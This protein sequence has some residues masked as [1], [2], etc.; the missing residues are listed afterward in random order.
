MILLN[1]EEWEQAV[2]S[3]ARDKPGLR[4]FL[5]AIRERSQLVSG[6]RLGHPSA[7]VSAR[8]QTVDGVKAEK[9]P[10]HLKKNRGLI[11]TSMPIVGLFFNAAIA[12]GEGDTCA[13]CMYFA[14]TQSGTSTSDSMIDFKCSL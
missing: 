1:D 5:A 11:S 4:A 7:V 14:G 10:C 3:P 9:V 13:P 2:S 12:C 8:S 6:L